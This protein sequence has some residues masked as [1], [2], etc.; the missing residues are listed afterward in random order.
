MSSKTPDASYLKSW[1]LEGS[2]DNQNYTLLDDQ[3]DRSDL[4]GPGKIGTFLVK[5]SI[6]CRYI[7]LGITGPTYK[8]DYAICI[9]GLEFFGGILTI[10]PVKQDYTLVV[11]V[12]T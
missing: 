1:N 4:N 5:K 9:S 11:S 12:Q 8:G 6:P 7:R 2:L 3:N 10:N